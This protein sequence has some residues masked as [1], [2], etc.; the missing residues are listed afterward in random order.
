MPG[1]W[2]RVPVG[3]PLPQ[4]GRGQPRAGHRS[5]IGCG[6]AQGMSAVARLRAG[7]QGRAGRLPPL[8]ARTNFLRHGPV[9][10]AEGSPSRCRPVVRA[11]VV[12]A[13]VVRLIL[14]P[15][16]LVPVIL[17]VECF[18][19]RVGEPRRW[20]P[21][22]AARSAQP[23]R[24]C[25]PWPRAGARARGRALRGPNTRSSADRRARCYSELSNRGL[26][27]GAAGRG[28]VIAR[29]VI[30]HGARDAGSV[31]FTASACLFD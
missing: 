23:W 6:V 15:V 13:D 12:R 19:G 20:R 2:E 31:H 10:S 14:V 27:T 4:W 5:G 3:R 8:L 25:A 1:A 17:A 11:G 9:V 22:F 16:I 24:P 18:R 29:A 28:Y 7:K 30:E 21:D 26:R